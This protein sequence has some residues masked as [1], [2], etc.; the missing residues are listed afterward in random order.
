MH[1]DY[2]ANKSPS[3]PKQIKLPET[4]ATDESGADC[5]PDLV[6]DCFLSLIGF[7]VHQLV[8]IVIYHLHAKLSVSR[9]SYWSASSHQGD[10]AVIRLREHAGI[11][12]G[13]RP[14]A[15]D[16]EQVPRVRRAHRAGLGLER[17]QAVLQGVCVVV[18]PLH[19]RLACDVVLPRR[20]HTDGVAS[21]HW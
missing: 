19:Q 17:R 9:K 1:C 15:A 6:R 4:R 7:D 10:R 16:D 21:T 8:L 12:S 14:S 20:L 3:E 13:R 18:L 5:F 2:T 11:G